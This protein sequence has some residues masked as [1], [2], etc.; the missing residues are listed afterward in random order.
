MTGSKI[1]TKREL[2][3]VPA[4][5]DMGWLHQS[6]VGEMGVSHT[7]QLTRM[8]SGPWLLGGSEENACL[9]LSPGHLYFPIA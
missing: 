1:K 2:A 9:L 5:D 6:W 4:R 7:K 3:L 8:V